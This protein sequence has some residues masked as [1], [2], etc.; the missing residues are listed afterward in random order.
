MGG[1]LAGGDGWQRRNP[2]GDD[3]ACGCGVSDLARRTAERVARESYG[4]LIA[5]VA[6]RTRDIASAEDALGDAFQAALRTWPERG[7]PDNPEGW[8]MTA[9]RRELGQRR[10]HA[11]VRDRAI[12]TIELMLAE[13]NDAPPDPFP[14]QRLK[15]LF[16][17]AHPA[18]DE[19][20]RTPLMLQTILGLDAAAIGAAFLVAPATMGQRLVR[21]KAKIRTAGLRFEEPDAERLSERLSAVLDAIYASYGTAWDAEVGADPSRGLGQEALYLARLIVGL[22]PNEPEP[23]GLLAMML[24]CEARTPAR[25][26]SDGSFVPLAEQRVELWSRTQIGEAE[27]LL[28]DASQAGQYGRYQTEAA[29]QSVHVIG[30]LNGQVQTKA[31]VMLYDLLAARNPTIGVFVARAAAYGA[32]FGAEAGL[33]KLDELSDDLVQSYQPFWA[34]RAHLQQLAGLDANL[35]FD[36]AIGLSIDPAVRMYLTSRKASAQTQ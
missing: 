32:A 16:V 3:G 7:V 10:R 33:A 22:L 14:D 34:C 5:L 30:A 9:A 36:R 12:P 28:R 13:A 19:S 20:V 31:L 23:K 6:A 21:A 1:A 17:C 27:A 15:L 35:A 29:I 24:Y 25:R 8:L 2:P 18:I 11:N 26:A 4:R